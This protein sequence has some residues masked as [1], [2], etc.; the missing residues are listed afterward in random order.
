MARFSQGVKKQSQKIEF[1]FD[2]KFPLSGKTSSGT[3]AG[4]VPLRKRL[5]AAPAEKDDSGR[6]WKFGSLE[7][8]YLKQTVI[9]DS[10]TM[11]QYVMDSEYSVLQLN[12][13]GKI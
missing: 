9:F 4:R 13:A 6:E 12:I 3:N 11:N 7:T 2:K 10:F 1:W 5:P 8:T